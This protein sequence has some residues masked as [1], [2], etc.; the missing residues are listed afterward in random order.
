MIWFQRSCELYLKH[1]LFIWVYPRQ[2]TNLLVQSSRPASWSWSP[3]CWAWSHWYRLVNKEQ[4][5]CQFFHSS[6]FRWLE[7]WFGRHHLLHFVVSSEFQHQLVLLTSLAHR[8]EYILDFFLA[9]ENY[10]VLYVVNFLDYLFDF[11]PVSIKWNFWIHNDRVV[12][13]FGK[14]IYIHFLDY[15]YILELLS[16]SLFLWFSSCCRWPR[17]RP[18]LSCIEECSLVSCRCAAFLINIYYTFCLRDMWTSWGSFF[19]HVSDFVSTFCSIRTF[20][21]SC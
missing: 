16:V 20:Q 8:P 1:K 9:F 15:L 3:A 18:W 10:L 14:G 6:I 5:H 13:A 21:I 7:N 2:V 4:A 17:I 19:R 12:Y 11:I